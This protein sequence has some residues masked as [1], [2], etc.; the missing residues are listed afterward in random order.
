VHAANNQ[1]A[2]AGPRVED[3]VA[4]RDGGKEFHKYLGVTIGKRLEWKAH[5]DDN[6]SLS[7]PKHRQVQPLAASPCVDPG[8]VERAWEQ[9]VLPCLLKGLA[10]LSMRN[11]VIRLTRFAC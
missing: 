10:G 8:V 1:L 5:V 3:K 2:L 6:V 9:K 4:H 11:H 7:K